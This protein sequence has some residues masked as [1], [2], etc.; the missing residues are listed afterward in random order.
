MKRLGIVAVHLLALPA[1]LA[2]SVLIN[3][4]M[5]ESPSQ[6]AV[7]QELNDTYWVVADFHLATEVIAFT[8]LT[9]VLA[10][11]YRSLNWSL[12]LAWVAC[13]LHVGSMLVHWGATGGPV[14]PSHPGGASVYLGSALTAVAATLLGLVLSLYRALQSARPGAM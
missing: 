13:V 9:T 10:G 5:P 8:L 4:M 7:R 6:D 2:F 1:A 14:P 12:G 11:F 3:A